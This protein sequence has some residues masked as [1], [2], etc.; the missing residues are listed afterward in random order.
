MLSHNR[1]MSLKPL[2]LLTTGLISGPLAATLAV[3]AQAQE[4][5]SNNGIFFEVPTVIEFEFIDSNGAYLSTFG[6]ENLNTGERTPLFTE[7]PD[8]E[9]N[10]VVIYDP[11]A[12]FEFEAHTPYAFYLESFYAGQPVGIIYSVNELNPN[13]EQLLNFDGGIAGLIEGGTLLRWDDTASALIPE[14]Q[15]DRDFN[16]FA[17]QAGG[18]ILCPFAGVPQVTPQP[19]VIPGPQ[20]PIEAPPADPAP[21]EPVPGLW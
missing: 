2:A 18:F 12:E 5:F 6:V 10:A 13:N 21:A 15:Q 4:Q 19:V 11:I 3:P 1:P 8:P 17:V 20:P 14:S 16:D 7:E 9:E